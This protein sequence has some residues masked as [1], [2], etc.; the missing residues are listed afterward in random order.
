MTVLVSGA[1]LCEEEP[2][3]ATERGFPGAAAGAGAETGQTESLTAALSGLDKLTVEFIIL[4]IQTAD[5]RNSCLNFIPPE[6][7]ITFITTYIDQ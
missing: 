6:N 3:R 5:T 1:G 4:Q 7:F 2:G